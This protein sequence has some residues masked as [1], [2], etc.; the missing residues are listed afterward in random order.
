M[1]KRDDFIERCRA[2]LSKTGPQNALLLLAS[3][4][5]TIS[6]SGDIIYVETLDGCVIRD[7]EYPDRKMVLAGSWPLR[8]TECIDKFGCIT[9]AGR[10]ALAQASR[11]AG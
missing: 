11:D 4:R 6:V 8:P 1:Q 5:I 7:P 9:A 10:T 3:G 2:A